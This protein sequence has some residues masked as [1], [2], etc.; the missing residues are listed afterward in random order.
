MIFNTKSVPQQ[1]KQNQNQNI[2][3]RDL[4]VCQMRFLL[5]TEEYPDDVFKISSLQRARRDKISSVDPKNWTG[6][7]RKAAPVGQAWTQAWLL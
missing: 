6:C 2:A 3:E 1:S 7:A 5:F 4:G